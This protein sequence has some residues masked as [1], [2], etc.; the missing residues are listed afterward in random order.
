TGLVPPNDFTLDHGDEIAI[1]VASV[2]TL[3][4]VVG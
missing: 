4:N 1:T 2:G 3:R